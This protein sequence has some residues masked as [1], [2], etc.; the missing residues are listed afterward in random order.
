MRTSRR[1]GLCR[2]FYC[3]GEKFEKNHNQAHPEH[4]KHELDRAKKRMNSVLGEYLEGLHRECRRTAPQSAHK[5]VSAAL[6]NPVGEENLEDQKLALH[7]QELECRRGAPQSA[8]TRNRIRSAALPPAVPP[9]ACRDTNV[10]EEHREARS[11]A[12]R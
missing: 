2:T 12:L 10:A 4:Q 8:V 9:A 7:D 11:S 6:L 3:F 5:C 1:W